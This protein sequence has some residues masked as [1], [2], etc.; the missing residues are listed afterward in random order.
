MLA[1]RCTR[2]YNYLVTFVSCVRSSGA[3]DPG[4]GS[5][6]HRCRP[7]RRGSAVHPPHHRRRPRLVWAGSNSCSRPDGPHGVR[8][9][10][11]WFGHSWH[12]PRLCPCSCRGRRPHRSYNR[13]HRAAN[14]TERDPHRRHRH[15]A[16]PGGTACSGGARSSRVP[17]KTAAHQQ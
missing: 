11:W 10:P 12:K 9:A 5:R 14:G 2:P 3:G 7:H 8:K 15:L 1:K 6:H 4:R 16:L 17:G 13:R